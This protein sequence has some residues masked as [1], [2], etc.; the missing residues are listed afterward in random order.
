MAAPARFHNPTRAAPSCSPGLRKSARAPLAFDGKVR[1]ARGRGL[2]RRSFAIS[3]LT[4]RSTNAFALAVAGLPT[5][6]PTTLGTGMR[7]R[8]TASPRVGTVVLL[9]LSTL[10]GNVGAQQLGPDQGRCDEYASCSSSTACAN[11]IITSTETYYATIWTTGPCS[12]G[13]RSFSPPVY[14]KWADG[15]SYY[16]FLYY[17][18]TTSRWGTEITSGSVMYH[19]AGSSY[20]STYMKQCPGSNSASCF[21]SP[22]PPPPA[23]APPPSP[24]TTRTPAPKTADKTVVLTLTASGSVSDYSDT[25]SLRRSIITV[26]GF[27]STVITVAAASVII[28]A[29]IAVPAPLASPA[30]LAAVQAT[31]SSTL[32]TAAAASAALGV[33][34]LTAPTITSSGADAGGDAASAPEVATEQPVSTSPLDVEVRPSGGVVLPDVDMPAASELARARRPPPPPPASAAAVGVVLAVG[35]ALGGTALLLASAALLGRAYFR[36]RATPMLRLVEREAQ[37][38]APDRLDRL[39]PPRR[40]SA[41][42]SL[43]GL[44]AAA[45]A[46]RA[47]SRTRAAELPL[48]V[49]CGSSLSGGNELSA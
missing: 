21:A 3:S 11:K 38:I 35:G 25:S 5:R 8:S 15:L 16:K 33:T 43:R 18:C 4:A 42:G 9:L 7:L 28:T 6:S 29:T 40:A 47:G 34:V 22:A 24:L 12:C 10:V 20:S 14:Q 46:A 2:G 17:S 48:E 41:S 44:A 32:G 37:T 13:G 1:A 36:R 30:Y 23:P 26:A 39:P 27:S 45:R 19:D 31:L 49:A